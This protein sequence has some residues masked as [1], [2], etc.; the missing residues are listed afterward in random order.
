MSITAVV[1]VDI[2]S[3][4]ILTFGLYFPRHGRKAMVVSYLTANIGLLAVSSVLSSASVPAG[5]GL[6]L[7]GILSIIRL[8]S[9]ELDHTE[10][11]YYFAS[12]SLGL[13][14]GLGG[15]FE[16][17]TPLMCAGILLGL[18]VGDHP[19]LFARYRNQI[20]TL[21]EAYTDEPALIARLEE[22]LGARVNHVTVRKTDLVN[23]TTSVDVRYRLPDDMS[24]SSPSVRS[25]LSGVRR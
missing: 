2:V 11:A 7:F 1:L 6:G 16:W 18:Y 23:D 14:A 4:L 12:L 25:L 5:L 8:R 13:F 22:L 17:G 3:I 15:A 21:D 9:D 10:I 19:T 24:T 20:M